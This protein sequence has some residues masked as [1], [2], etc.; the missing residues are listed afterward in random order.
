MTQVRARTSFLFALLIAA[1]VVLAACGGGGG[2]DATPEAGQR[3]TTDPALVPTSTPMQ[4]PVLFTIQNNT[5]TTE[6][7]TS[8]TVAG[9]TPSATSPQAYTVESGDTCSAIAAK[10][11]VALEDLLKANRNIDSTCSNIHPG[12]QLIV[13]GGTA[14]GTNGSNSGAAAATATGTPSPRA[15]GG[16]VYTVVDGDTCESIAASAGISTGDLLAA[17]PSVGSDCKGLQ[18][19]QELKLP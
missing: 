18:I 16:S 5:I 11:G 3:R 19:G 14:N 10:L 17:N 13:P 9:G 1:G 12:D 4:D 6:G 7:G 8:A 2:D 15:G